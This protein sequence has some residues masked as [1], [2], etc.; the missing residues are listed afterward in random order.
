MRP[1]RLFLFLLCCSSVAADQIEFSNGDRISGQIQKLDGEHLVVRTD[2]A[3]E[4]RVRLDAV[5]H[6]TT[7]DAVRVVLKDGR[8]FTGRLELREGMG[9][10][11]PPEGAP[12]EL[13]AGQIDALRSATEQTEYEARQAELA[14]AQWHAASDV[15]FAMTRGNSV[16]STLNTSGIV[17]RTTTESRLT[18]NA[19][20]LFAS[21]RDS[22]GVTETTADTM[23][24]GGRYDRNLT[25]RLFAF[26]FGELFR[27]QL[28][29]LDL[30]T[31]VGAGAGWRLRDTETLGFDVFGGGT[32]TNEK[33]TL[34][35]R[36]AAEIFGGEEL[37]WKLNDTLSLKESFAI[38]PNLSRG[39]E[40]RMTFD[41]SLEGKLSAWL[42]WH[43]TFTD[44]F[45]SDPPLGN[46]RNDLLL[47]TGLR[48]RF[49]KERE[50]SAA[51]TSR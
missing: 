28:Q 35:T 18:F 45:V 40:Y 10:I 19:S 24:F 16:T 41:S 36:N 23:L 51:A 47:T 21:N 33:F 49:G 27:N 12:V 44:R 30:R 5:R 6:L 50:F 22:T 8:K 3:D 31:T 17:T 13:A 26:G 9:T 48:L 20:T 2:Y 46:Q 25:E 15:G 29:D 34:V 32:Y 43:L 4:L 1:V 14:R 11:A 38:F 37:R 42:S 7:T 39:G